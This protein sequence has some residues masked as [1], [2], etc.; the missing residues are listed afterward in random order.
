MYKLL[1]MAE[2][3][4]FV[5]EGAELTKEEADNLS[6]N[7]GSRWIFYPFHLIIKDNGKVSINQRI[8]DAGDCLEHTIGMAIKRVQKNMSKFAKL[9]E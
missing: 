5:I 4:S 2:D 3:G 1:L 8:I 6:A 9:Y 7:M